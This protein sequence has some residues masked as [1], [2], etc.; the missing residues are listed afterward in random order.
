M[1]QVNELINL[2][3][4]LAGTVLFYVFSRGYQ[5]PTFRLLYAGFFMVLLSDLFT[6]LEGL[7]WFNLFNIL[8]HGALLLAG[9]FF[10]SEIVRM[11]RQENAP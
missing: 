8:E 1:I 10:L 3:L 2:L 5:L 9:V 4:T 6:V 11:S 7:L